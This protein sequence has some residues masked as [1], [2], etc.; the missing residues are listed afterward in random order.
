MTEPMTPNLLQSIESKRVV[1]CA[2]P[3]GVGKTTTSAALALAQARLGRK[4]CVL[5]ID[6]ARRLADALGV[7]L[8]DDVRRVD[9]STLTG[10][11]VEVSGELWALMLDPAKTFDSLI[12]RIAPSEP[13]AQR[14]LDNVM[15]RQVSRALAGT[16]EYTAVEKLYDLANTHSFDLIIVDTPPSKNVIDFLEAPQWLARFFEENVFKW[17]VLLDPEAPAASFGKS[18]L[19]RTGRVVW[20]VLGKV[21]GRELVL[22]F[23]S[24]MRAIETMAGDFRKRAEGIEE[25]LRSDSTLFLVVVTPDSLVMRDGNTLYK[26]IARR[27]I[28]F[29]GFV[30]N[31][32]QAPSGVGHVEE[33]VAEITSVGNA[34]PVLSRV[35]H[36]MLVLLQDT[37]RLEEQEHVAM[38]KLRQDSGWS[39]L[40][41]KVPTQFEEIHDLGGLHRLSEHF[42]S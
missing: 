20:D 27:G 31:R 1:L 41:A 19:K 11:A 10:D 34:H 16:L 9:T 32:T 38:D 37:Q 28:S 3:G 35:T 36:K 4:V 30:V 15:Y 18:V 23:A 8:G 33:A 29:G 5:T 13:V 25:L 7:T 22:E 24:F 14:L 39:G 12:R 26:E 17:F 2:G 21:L 42:A 6:P 40:F